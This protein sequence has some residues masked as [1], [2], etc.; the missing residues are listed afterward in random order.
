MSSSGIKHDS[1]F[2]RSSLQKK[3]NTKLLELLDET[4]YLLTMDIGQWVCR[5]CTI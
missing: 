3:N 2:Y 5:W 1:P 4:N